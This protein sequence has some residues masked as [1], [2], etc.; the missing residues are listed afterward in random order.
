MNDSHFDFDDAMSYEQVSAGTDPSGVLCNNIPCSF[1]RRDSLLEILHGELMTMPMD[2]EHGLYAPL[3]I[4]G[5]LQIQ[6]KSRATLKELQE[7]EHRWRDLPMATPHDYIGFPA[8]APPLHNTLINK[9]A[10]SVPNLSHTSMSSSSLLL[11]SHDLEDT[12]SQHSHECF[13]TLHRTKIPKATSQSSKTRFPH[14]SSL[15]QRT[16]Q[17]SLPSD[18]IRFDAK[19][20]MPK[21]ENG[22]FPLSAPPAPACKAVG[23]VDS[24]QRLK[25]YH[26]EKWSIRFEEL[27]HFARS[28][29]HAAVPHTYPP[30]PVLARWV[31]WQRR[32]YKL[33]QEGKASTMTTERWLQLLSI[34]FVWDSHEVKW[35]EKLA[36]L[37]SYR[38]E[39]GHC[40]V[41]SNF[42]LKQL[43]TWVKCQRRQYKL[44][45]KGKP[46]AMTPQRIIMLENE[47]FTWGVQ[48]TE[49]MSD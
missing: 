12:K 2:G 38:E 23:G 10:S 40:S 34:G 47:G 1:V 48:K 24:A 27:Q 25:E 30:H 42:K 14:D 13:D 45:R 29:G 7:L 8:S 35:H 37:V 46:S 33:L 15:L 31:K 17:D 19:G 39:N 41:P 28:N 11:F 22:T 44:L 36:A 20:S 18:N 26:D 9:G 5:G 32:Q 4:H 43:A 49:L 16:N 3:S 21:V 6:R